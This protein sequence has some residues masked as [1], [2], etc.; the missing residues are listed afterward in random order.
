LKNKYVII[1]AGGVGSRM[2]ST[3]P[4]QFIEINGKPII[5]HTI[6]K[7]HQAIEEI[8][9]ILV[10]HPDYIDYYKTLV[11][12]HNFNIPCTIT[13]GGATRYHSSLNGIELVSNDS[14]V[15]IHDAARP[16]IS[17]KHIKDLFAAAEV[18]EFV[19]PVLDVKESL[20][21][22][23]DSSSDVVNRSKYKVVQ[24]PQVFGSE[25]LKESY[26]KG[27]KYL[28]TDDASVVQTEL[29]RTP[30]LIIGEEQNIKITTP[31]DMV[32][33]QYILGEDRN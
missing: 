1:V 10:L 33:A 16:L 6:E 8:N 21:L 23:D 32:I 2:E 11:S 26:S 30:K 28:Y 13:N 17:A 22:I 27:Y 25:L 12:N 4:K 19:V 7:F 5:F 31:I 24:T 20:R 9:I 18:S 3:I 15:A 14:I 29:G